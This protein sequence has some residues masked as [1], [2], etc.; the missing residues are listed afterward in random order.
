MK[1]T[2]AEQWRPIPG[3]E[4]IYE[5]SDHGRVRS[6]DRLII[7][8][9]GDRHY[10][11]GRVLSA[12]DNGHG[13]L[14]VT[15]SRN[16]LEIRRYVHRLVLETFIGPAPEGMEA[17]HGNAKRHDNRLS[18]LRWGTKLENAQDIL[19]SGNSPADWTHCR[20]GHEFTPENTIRQNSGR[21]ACREC[22][23]EVKRR[24]RARLKEK[25]LREQQG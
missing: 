12:C 25:K 22:H 3:W 8:A 15:L 14:T 20:R 23:K 21:R 9:N 1:S 6:L 4:G 16:N 11:K 19:K 2:Q 5:A 24:Y 17:C 10:T 18:N 7:Y 13:Y